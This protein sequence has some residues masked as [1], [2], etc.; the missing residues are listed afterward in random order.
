MID[1]DMEALVR[2]M[3]VKEFLS[4]KFMSKVLATF[5]SSVV[6][7]DNRN[8]ILGAASRFKPISEWFEPKGTVEELLEWMDTEPERKIPNVGSITCNNVRLYVNTVLR[9]QSFSPEA[10]AVLA[11]L[12]EK[13]G[14]CEP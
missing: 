6:S 13:I 14:S 10:D 7:V 12:K 5:P 11:A 4:Y 8:T 2:K 1:Q 9:R 3:S